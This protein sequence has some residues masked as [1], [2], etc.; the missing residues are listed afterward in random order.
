[1]IQ[2]VFITDILSQMHPSPITLWRVT[3]IFMLF[4]LSKGNFVEILSF[5]FCLNNSECGAY[6]AVDHN[7]V[8]S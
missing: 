1:M 3:L 6:L 8:Q 7:L 4:L 2:Q 5:G